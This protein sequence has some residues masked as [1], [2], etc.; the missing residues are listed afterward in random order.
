MLASTL[1]GAEPPELPVGHLVHVAGLF[2]INENRA[3][4]ALSRMVASGEVTT[5]GD[6]RYRLAGH[7]LQRQARQ[8]VSRA[9]RTARW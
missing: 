5:S 6:G 9:G 4:V 3:R 1:L 8:T 7:L 2:G